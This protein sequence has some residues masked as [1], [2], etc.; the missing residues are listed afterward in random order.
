MAH[1][2]KKIL[3]A[4][5]KVGLHQFEPIKTTNLVADLNRQKDDVL[6]QKLMENAITLVQNKNEILPL[7]NLELHKIAYVTMGN[8][9]ATP[10][11]KTLNKYSK[12]DPVSANNL[13]ELISA[14]SQYN[15][16][17][18]GLH[19][20]NANPWKSYQF[21]DKELVWLYEIARTNTLF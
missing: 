2:V 20:S 21:T 17:I 19:T 3:S 9:D 1:S 12:V 18:V 5:Y 15:T 4:K 8:A 13:D 14:L 11:I 16:V 7:K 6:Y 10:F